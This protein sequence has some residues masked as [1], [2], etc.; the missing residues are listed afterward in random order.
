MLGEPKFTA[1]K[2][3]FCYGFL[4]VLLASCS[5]VAYYSMGLQKVESPQN[6]RQQFGETKVVSI[7][8]GG[9][10]KYRYEDD[11]IRVT[12]FVLPKQFSF[13]LRNK[14]NHTI[15]INWDDISMIDIYGNAKRVIHSGVK[16]IEK[17]NSQ[18]P[19]N[20]PKGAAIDD[21]L[22]PSENISW[23][24]DPWTGSG[25]Q[26]AYLLPCVY[27]NDS[28]KNAS[29]QHLIGKTMSIM[30][31]IMIENTQNDYVFTFSVDKLVKAQKNK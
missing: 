30:M 23:S 8:E 17:N 20:I 16:Y 22:I 19:T 11:F 1:M 25:W 29:A 5:S 12:W 14:S 18:P 7:T 6:A 21:I 28:L 2:K 4:F 15:K 13:N 24:Y 27:K 26:T 31:P 3:I 9:V 10:E